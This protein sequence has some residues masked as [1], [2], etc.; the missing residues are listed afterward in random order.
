MRKQWSFRAL[1]ILLVMSLLVTLGEQGLLT[2][3]NNTVTVKASGEAGDGS[4]GS[5]I[6]YNGAVDLKTTGDDTQKQ[7]ENQDNPDAQTPSADNAG[8]GADAQGD[9]DA[10]DGADADAARKLFSDGTIHLYNYRQLQLVGTGAK[11]TDADDSVETIGL[12]APVTD[13]NGEH[14]TYGSKATYF[15][16]DDITLPEDAV[17]VLPFDFEGGFSSRERREKEEKEQEDDGEEQPPDGS[18]DQPARSERLY[19]VESDTIYIQNIYQLRTLA[20]RDRATIPVMTG[21]WSAEKFGVGQLIYP[22]DESQG[23]LTYSTS[24][25]YVISSEFSAS[26]PEEVS[27]ALR[28]AE[29]IRAFAD[30]SIDHVDGRDYFGQPAVTIDGTQYILIGDRAQLDAINKGRVVAGRRNEIEVY[31]PVWKVELSR[32]ESS[33]DNW[34]VTSATLIYPG[35]A[36][37]I[38]GI[39]VDGTNYNFRSNVMYDGNNGILSSD[40]YHS[41]A[42]GANVG[43]TKTTYCTIN[44]D[45]CETCKT[46]KYDLSQTTNPFSDLKYTTDGNYIVFRDIDMGGQSNEWNPMTFNGKMYGVKASGGGSLWDAG[47]TEMNLDTGVKPVISN[48]YCVPVMK[49]GKLDVSAQMGVGFFGTL[50]PKNDRSNLL[51]TDVVVSN[52]KLSNGRVINECTECDMD[53][54][55][56][57]LLLPLVGGVVATLLDPI[58]RELLGKN[59][60]NT[61]KMLT[62]L[63][64]ARRENPS[65]LATGAFAGRAVG[66]VE[67][68]FCEVENMQVKTVKTSF[69]E[70]GQIVG[71][72]GFVGYVSGSFVYEIVSQAIQTIV[73]GLS[74]VLNLIPGVGLGDLINVLLNNALPAGNLIPVGYNNVRIRSCK[75]ING[76]LSQEN[77][78][79]GVGGFAGSVCGSEIRDS[80]VIAG[81]L[82]VK[83]DHFG[84]GFVGV[85]RDDVIKQ[86]LGDLGVNIGSLY[87]LS[88]IIHCSVEVTKLEVSG[89]SYLGGFAG[90][91]AN[92]HVIES[93]INASN[94]IKITASGDYIGGFTGRSQLG[95]SF[96][97]AEFIPGTGSLLGTVKDVVT[98]ALSN[99]ASQI[100]LALGGVSQ[101]AIVGCQINGR[102]ELGTSGNKIG[103]V[104]GDG[105]AAYV[106]DSS[107]IRL[108]VRYADAEASDLP[109][110]GSRMTRVSQLARV[111]AEGD[112]AGGIAGHLLSAYTASLLGSTLGLQS[113][114]GFQISDVE[115]NGVSAGYTVETD[116]DYAGGGAGFAIGGDVG[117]S[118]DYAFEKYLSTGGRQAQYDAL[119]DA[120]K[121]EYRDEHIEEA[122]SLCVDG[123]ERSVVLRNLKF[124]SGHNHVGGF[125]GTTGPDKVVGGNGLNLNLL[126]LEVL[127]IDNLVGLTS[128]IHTNYGNCFVIGIDGGYYVTATGARDEF[129]DTDTTDFTAGGFAG[130]TTSVTMINCRATNLSY[131][132]ADDR[133]GK[134]GGFVGH[135]MAGNLAAVSAEP[136]SG[137]GLINIGQLVQI[138]ADLVPAFEMCSVSFVDQAYV[139]A[140]A[141]GG[142]AGEFRSG[143]VNLMGI[144]QDADSPYAVYNI[145]HVQGGKFAGGFGGKVHSGALQRDGGSGLSLLGGVAEID[146]S[147]ITSITNA[148]LPRIN[149]AGVNSP[150]GFTVLAAY[151]ADPDDKLSPSRTGYAGGFIGYGSGMEVSH[152]DVNRLANRTPSVPANLEEKDGS[153]YM[154]YGEEYRL[155][156]E[157][158]FDGVW[159]K[160]PYSVAGALYAGGYIGY[161]NVG[162]SRA[163]GDSIK[164]LDESLR[165]TA[166]LE[167]LQMVISTIEHSDVYGAPGGFSVL[168]SSHVLLGDGN[169][170]EKGVGYAGGFAGKMAGAHIQDSSALNF[171]YVISEIA[172]GG[173]V[174]EMIPGDVA[175]VLDYN[176][177]EEGSAFTDLFSGVLDT[178]DLLQVVEAFVPTVYNS[179][180]TCIPCGGAVRAQSPSDG[181]EADIP[182][183]RGFAGGFVGHDAGAQIWGNSDAPWMSDR[184]YGTQEG[185]PKRPCDAVRIRSVYGAEFAGGYVGLMEP[186]STAATGSL[187]VL[188]GVIKAKNL[189]G[190]LNAV[191]PT[192]ENANVYGPL[193]QLDARTW[194]AWI[195]YVGQYGGFAGELANVGEVTDEN[196]DEKMSQFIYGYHVVAG[197]DEFDDSQTTILSG[198]A[199]GYA[200]AV[201]SG[202]IRYAVANNAKQVRAMKSAGG[203]VGE[204]QTEGLAQL[205]EASIL[206]LTLSLDNLL[207]VAEV[208]VPVAFEAGVNGYQNGLIV[209]AEGLPTAEKVVAGDETRTVRT[210]GGYAG[211]FVGLCN[212][213]QI[214]NRADGRLNL[215]TEIPVDGT[216]V[217]NLKTV[218]GSNCIGGFAGKTS[219][220]SV[221]NADDSDASNGIVQ[222]LLDNVISNPPQLLDVLGATI[223]VIGKAEVTAAKPEWGIVVDGEYTDAQGNTRYARCAGGFVGSAE[224][225]V[226]GARNTPERTL[227]VTGLRGVSGGEYAGGFFGL[228]QVSSVAEVGSSDSSTSVLDLVKAGNVSV[229]DVFRTYIYHATVTGVED[230]VRIIANDMSASGKFSTYR[231]SGAAGGFGGGL[232]NGTVQKSSVTGLNAAQAPN[233]AGG[234]VGI[235]ST[236]SG[237]SA[238]ELGMEPDAAGTELLSGLGL[239][240]LGANAQLL[241]VVGS[242]LTN[243]SVKGFENGFIVRTSNIQTVEAGVVDANT[244]ISSCAAGFVGFADMAHIE[245]CAAEDFK[246][247]Q[248]TQIAAGFVGRT[249]ANSLAEIEVNSALTGVIVRIVNELL[250][251]LYAEQLENI[252]VINV[253][254]EESPLSFNVLSDGDLLYVNLMG[255]KIGVALNKTDVEGEKDTAIIT[256]GTSTIKLPCDEENGVGDNPDISIALIEGNRTDIKNCSVT[257]IPE[258]YDV[259]AGGASETADGTDPFGYAGGFVAYNKAGMISDSTMLLCDVIRGTE[260][261]EGKPS[262]VGPFVAFTSAGERYSKN[263]LEK[264]NNHY[265]IYRTDNGGYTEAD[266]TED[267][268]IGEAADE[269]VTVNGDSCNRYE[270]THRAVVQAHDDLKDA[271]ETGGSGDSRA[272]LAYV[273]PA[274]E[275]L[276]LNVPL[277][278]NGLGDTPV[279]IDLKDPCDTEID[280]TV[281]KVWKDFIYLSSRPDEIKV[282][283]ARTEYGENRP[284]EMIIAGSTE[285]LQNVSELTLDNS[286]GSAWATTWQAILERQPVAVRRTVD[287][288]EKVIYYQY[289]VEEVG[290][291]NYKASY[292]VDQASATARIINRYTGPLLPGTG[293]AGVL[294]FYA[295]GLFLLI[296]GGMLL[297]LCRKDRR[298]PAAAVSPV[299]VELDLS[300]FS[301]FFKD[302]K[303]KK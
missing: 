261:E 255:L 241:N 207:K 157:N 283:I 263:E 160:L 294:M 286:G 79:Y 225:T 215:V 244:L 112:F 297:I 153:A 45:T 17:W 70:N 177:E 122:I 38:D 92:S 119:S 171:N 131:V 37:L 74:T 180:T 227:K 251:T 252:D 28:G 136:S 139:R 206:G 170:D 189:L 137:G 301:D 1:A 245:D 124:V 300:D 104:I 135:A 270:A 51:G 57:S 182:V 234:F 212:G 273:S 86:T 197:R 172:A 67:I 159:E 243:C 285:G 108:V 205:G 91:Q 16:E 162:S 31:G 193:E 80:K 287:G 101:S 280:V 11:L 277:D 36:D 32:P 274:M 259:F 262:K 228:A 264:N 120:E 233:Y 267:S 13:E 158:D 34:S 210:E 209:R 196:V 49:N 76:S 26:Q 275:V 47:H 97:L 133:A 118:K 219:A 81:T 93:D 94:S 240:D 59:G 242:T 254:T 60:I 291:E 216:W 266:D 9:A 276:M 35:D 194:N 39:N 110:S 238:D 229:L 12:G 235:C 61:N 113:Y 144:S 258:G 73:D 109:T 19:D 84:G 257:G 46:C 106:I 58:L 302:L 69:E 152:C 269:R 154:N 27:V 293:G 176:A 248:S 116:G 231:V 14:V 100:L 185:E 288:Q 295:I 223:T 71:K 129:D 40:A 183:K 138:G 42:A 147:G 201:Y 148:Y 246:Y 55:L 190:A 250:K 249:D 72:G 173:Y 90:V 89:R 167:G 10:Q 3:G 184:K 105:E 296:G 214:G 24:H 121:S 232:M 53:E 271:V 149:Y 78:K 168:A 107:D 4:F 103:G 165:T 7:P 62:E 204:M 63:L 198:C 289:V 284:A 195:R 54:T 279:T 268:V 290:F 87:P 50:T 20:D 186:G 169:Y 99:N 272:L 161:M 83:A 134:A 22:G 140:N 96:G 77:G 130:D 224:A 18:E 33:G 175:D 253:G 239:G 127:S 52:L 217:R 282:R 151:I 221:A 68:T 25:R 211:G 23:Y 218:T 163:L 132:T 114:L 299:D 8:D 192:I 208:L 142:F 278:D 85:E 256:I 179:R 115:I 220:A 281:I 156:F 48:L 5:Y 21:D 247:A 222:G 236:S 41:L 298:Y 123:N 303:K 126:G 202:V 30:P 174:G 128:G 292:D 150:E 43:R 15:L 75:V 213:A 230:G 2:L 111:K 125:V 199:G 44:P 82:S 88:E 166:V 64:D 6:T 141:A 188:G 181:R 98:S 187:S 143:T 178:D 65:A 155:T 203:F 95:T 145:G 191:Y 226:C 146:V 66:G 237:V 102:L 56:I 29:P 260:N 265:S 164:L 200:G 117:F